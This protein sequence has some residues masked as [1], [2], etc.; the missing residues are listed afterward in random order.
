MEF[1]LQGYWI[2]LPCPSPGDLPET[3]IKPSSPASTGRFFTA[4]PPENPI[5]NNTVLYMWKFL[6][7]LIFLKWGIVDV[8]FPGGSDGKESAWKAGDLG[9]IPGS[10]R[11]PEEGNGYPLQYSG[12]ENSMDKGAWYATVYVVKKSWT[13]LSNEYFHFIFIVDVQYFINYRWITKCF[14]V[15]KGYVPFTVIIKYWLYPLCCTIYPCCLL[16]TY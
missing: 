6:G 15:F 1:S 12:L 10:G 5:V 7:E 13:R 11:C 3:G 8:G 2:Q 14:T 9:S 16:Y 4:E